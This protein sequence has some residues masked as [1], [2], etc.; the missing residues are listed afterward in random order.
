MARRLAC[1]RAPPGM[2]IRR[3]SALARDS[4]MESPASRL[5]RF[6][7]WVFQSAPPPARRIIHGETSGGGAVMDCGGR[8][9]RRHRFCPRRSRSRWSRLA[10]RAQ[11]KRWR[12]PAVAGLCH[13]SPNPSGPGSWVGARAAPA[14]SA[15]SFWLAPPPARGGADRIESAPHHSC[16]NFRH[17][18]R[19][20]LSAI[21]RRCYIVGWRTGLSAPRS[22]ARREV[23]GQIWE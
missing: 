4:R 19:A 9:K 14:N 2:R 22:S 10:L 1:R 5:P 8:A 20:I 17:V 3:R 12:R 13:R 23:S 11:P 18:V 7:V 15:R 16:G 21:T 6:G